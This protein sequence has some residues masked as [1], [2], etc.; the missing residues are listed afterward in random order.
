MPGEEIVHF[1]VLTGRGP[2]RA[3]RNLPESFAQFAGNEN[4]SSPLSPTPI[5]RQSAQVRVA[6]CGKL[7]RALEVVQ[8]THFHHIIRGHESRFDLEY[9]YA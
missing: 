9:Q 5:Y 8:R 1:G 2:G 4:V 7:L 3:A 6:K